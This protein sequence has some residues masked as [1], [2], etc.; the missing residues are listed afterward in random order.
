GGN[1]YLYCSVHTYTSVSQEAVMTIRS[2]A[3]TAFAYPFRAVFLVTAA[4]A[5]K[6]IAAWGLF[7]F[8]AWQLPFGWAPMQWHTHEMIYGFFT[9]AIAGLLLTAITNWTGAPPLRGYKLLLLVLLWCAGR[10][11]MWTASWLP[12]WLVA[13]VDLLF[14]PVLTIYVSLVLLRYNNRRNLI[15][16]GVL[17]FLAIGNL[18]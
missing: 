16:V 4:Y 7:L 12:G 9:A 2:L 10:V 1:V 17:L 14:L 15:L 11:V 5:L 3:T 18:V 6:L 8:A 13:L